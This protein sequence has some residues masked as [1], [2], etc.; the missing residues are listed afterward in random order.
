MNAVAFARGSGSLLTIDLHAPCPV[1]SSAPYR[2]GWTT[3]RY[4]VIKT[5]PES[6]D[7]KDLD[8]YVRG[9]LEG[10]GLPPDLCVVH[11]TAVDVRRYACGFAQEGEISANSW[12][13]VGLGNITSAGLS[14]LWNPK[15]GTINILAVVQGQMS[16]SAMVEAIQIVTEV[17]VRCLMGRRTPE[18]Y[19]ATGTST[20]TVSIAS[21]PGPELSFCGAVTPQG[22]ALARSVE[23]ALTKALARV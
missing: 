19:P 12:V 9:N 22:R 7:E 18:G 3:A 21:L 8:R 1:L 16:P 20:D 2:G 13:T 4:L 14:P 6:F 5:V 17:K 10:A 15:R 11:L 23:Q